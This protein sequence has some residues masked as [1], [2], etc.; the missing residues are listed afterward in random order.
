ME[1][2]ARWYT[3]EGEDIQL[4]PTPQQIVVRGKRLIRSQGLDI[5]IK[6]PF[7]LSASNPRVHSV[8]PA[9]VLTPKWN[10]AMLSC[11]NTPIYV[12]GSGKTAMDIIYHLAGPERKVG[13]CTFPTQNSLSLPPFLFSISLRPDPTL[14]YML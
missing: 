6:V 10:A 7:T 1:V 12:V 14:S 13:P 9:Q 3:K 8:S 11:P 5:K 2:R 4:P